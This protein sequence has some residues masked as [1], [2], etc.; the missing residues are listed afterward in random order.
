MSENIFWLISF[1]LCYYSWSHPCILT[2]AHYLCDL[3]YV[4]TIGLKSCTTGKLNRSRLNVA[5][6]KPSSFHVI[7]SMAWHRYLTNIAVILRASERIINQ[8]R[9]LLFL[10]I[11]EKYTW[12]LPQQ[13]EM[14][15]TLQWQSR[16]YFFFIINNYNYYVTTLQRI[17]LLFSGME[18][19]FQFSFK[20]HTCALSPILNLADNWNSK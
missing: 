4:S 3:F 7:G 20:L 16:L 1:I 14:K 2:I 15:I 17:T 12:Y 5:C 18:T 9:T 11:S 8:Q 10:L 13:M 19:H 6:P